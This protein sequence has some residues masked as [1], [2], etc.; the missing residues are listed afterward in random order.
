MTMKTADKCLL[1]TDDKRFSRIKKKQNRYCDAPSE[2]GRD[3]R[4]CFA[5]LPNSYLR[6]KSIEINNRIKR[7]YFI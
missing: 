5:C 6:I 4:S 7:K 3:E 1:K 2:D